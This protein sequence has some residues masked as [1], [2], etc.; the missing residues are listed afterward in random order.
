MKLIAASIFHINSEFSEVYLYETD[1]NDDQECDEGVG[2]DPLLG[3]MG[4]QELAGL[5]MLRSQ[6]TE[7]G[8]VSKSAMVTREGVQFHVNRCYCD[9]NE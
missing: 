5:S 6:I 8:C 2:S 1:E 4:E 3:L 9:E 7:A